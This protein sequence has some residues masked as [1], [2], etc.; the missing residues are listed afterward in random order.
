MK[1]DLREFPAVYMNLERHKEKNESMYSMLSGMGFKTIE[2]IEGVLDSEN[3]VAGCSKA[4]NRAL[5]TY[6][7]PFILFEDDCV[8]SYDAYQLEFEIPDDAEAL[9]LGISSWGRM[10]GHNGFYNQYDVL[11]EYPNIL[12]IYNMLSGH[13]VLYLSDE[14]LNICRRISRHAGYVICD[15]QDTGFADIQRYFNVY[16]LNQP[17]FHQVDHPI[18]T[19]SLLTSYESRPCISIEPQNFYPYLIK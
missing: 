2:R 10:N 3:S 4:H 12:R 11:S 6:E 8:I 15:Y 18:G 14:Y 7:A 19:R 13:S 17:I 5:E 9:Y 1:I 16:S